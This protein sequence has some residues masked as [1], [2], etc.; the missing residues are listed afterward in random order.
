MFITISTGVP[1]IIHLPNLTQQE[2]YE[3][4]AIV[5]AV[6]QETN[7]VAGQEQYL[8]ASR[9]IELKNSELGVSDEQ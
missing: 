4:E 8:K 7:I 5:K 3:T 2:C 6:M 9:C 1:V